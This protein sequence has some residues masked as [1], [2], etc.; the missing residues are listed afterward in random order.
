MAVGPRRDVMF[1]EPGF[2]TT[3]TL[4]RSEILGFAERHITKAYYA[5]LELKNFSA[6][7][8]L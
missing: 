3:L 6:K 1:I 5:P 7:M 2:H 4:R 8:L